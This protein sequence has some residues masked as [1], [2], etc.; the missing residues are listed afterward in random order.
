VSPPSAIVVRPAKTR[1]LRLEASSLLRRRGRETGDKLRARRGLLI[2]SARALLGSFLLGA[3]RIRH[4]R[5]A[6]AERL[7][8]ANGGIFGS[9]MF[10]LGIKFGA[11]EYHGC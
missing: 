4:D 1:P 10:D 2:S 5:A 8:P 9:L 6:V 7:I 11:Q 3:D